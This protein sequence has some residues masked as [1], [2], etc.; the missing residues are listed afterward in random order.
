MLRQ[1]GA[2]RKVE[3][4]AVV[5]AR[6][7]VGHLADDRRTVAPQPQLRPGG[8]RGVEIAGAEDDVG[9]DAAH[10]FRQAELGHVSR[11]AEPDQVEPCGHFRGERSRVVADDEG[12]AAPFRQPA[13]REAQLRAL[14]AAAGQVTGISEN[15]LGDHRRRPPATAWPHTKVTAISCARPMR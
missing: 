14:D 15:V 13:A 9:R 6:G 10:D 5:A 7:G 11:R 12:D 8:D 4:G 3:D 2:V 1:P